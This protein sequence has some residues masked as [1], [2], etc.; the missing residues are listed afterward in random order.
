MYYRLFFYQYI[1]GKIKD[2][3]SQL[4]TALLLFYD[5]KNLIFEY[6]PELENSKDILDLI[7][8]FNK[9]K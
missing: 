3:L 5:Q 9:S 4:E 8:S 2:A 6:L 7:S 1:I